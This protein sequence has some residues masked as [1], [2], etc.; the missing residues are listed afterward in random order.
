[1]CG[2]ATCSSRSARP[3]RTRRSLPLSFPAQ[4]GRDRD[5]AR[6]T[7][8]EAQQQ[9]RARLRL[10]V[11]AE[12]A[13]APA[14]GDRDAARL[15][16]Q[17]PPHDVLADLPL[18]LSYAVGFAVGPPAATLVLGASPGALW[19]LAGAVVLAAGAAGLALERR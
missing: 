12:R 17:R 4:V 18:D 16:P 5:D 8:D 14:D 11:P 2:P 15:Y 10:D 19:P 3:K 1:R 9:L 13:V 6:H 7:I